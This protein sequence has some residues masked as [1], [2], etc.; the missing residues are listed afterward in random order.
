MGSMSIDDMIRIANETNSDQ[1]IVKCPK[2]TEIGTDTKPQVAVEIE[3][4]DK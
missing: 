4:T 3:I 1:V 2:Q